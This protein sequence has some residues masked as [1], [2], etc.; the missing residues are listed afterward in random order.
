MIRAISKTME[1][2]LFIFSI[3]LVLS[4]CEIILKNGF[5]NPVYSNYNLFLMVT[6]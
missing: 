6:K 5:H 3:W 1:T 2:L 4:Y